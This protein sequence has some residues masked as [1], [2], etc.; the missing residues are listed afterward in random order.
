M[1][2]LLRRKNPMQELIA[3]LQQVYEDYQW[4]PDARILEQKYNWNVLVY[5][6]F[7]QGRSE[8]GDFIEPGGVRFKGAAFTS[9]N[10]WVMWRRN[11][12]SLSFPIAMSHIAGLVP[13]Q[14]W[15][16]SSRL[17][18]QLKPSEHLSNPWGRIKGEI[19]NCDT[20][21]I[22]E[23]DRAMENGLSF[24]RIRVNVVQPFRYKNIKTNTT[25]PEYIK[26]HRVWMYVGVPEYWE[27]LLDCNYTCGVVRKF[28]QPPNRAH[29]QLILGNYYYYSALEEDVESYPESHTMSGV[30][31][32]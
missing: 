21:R 22:F 31:I 16:T 27:K 26:E 24:K 4:S 19:W 18:T 11:L 1:L 7:M 9:S 23:L 20:Q 28:P 30:H 32:L 15:I 3:E 10:Q 17:V 25:T 8:H 14:P 12:G 5:N 6:E 13:G 29:S 2:S